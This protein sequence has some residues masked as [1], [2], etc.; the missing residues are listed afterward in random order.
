MRRTTMNSV[1][2]CSGGRSARSAPTPSGTAN[3][4]SAPGTRRPAARAVSG[5]FEDVRQT[6]E[7]VLPV[8][9]LAADHR[10]GI[11]SGPEDLVPPD[12]EVGELHRQGRPGRC[13]A[14]GAWCTR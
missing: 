5:Q 12:R 1:T 4:R 8:A 13:I 9:E 14:L 11:I 10:L 7:L 3:P 6:G 2:P